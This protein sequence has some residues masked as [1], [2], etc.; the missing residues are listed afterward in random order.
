[1]LFQFDM[2]AFMRCS[3]ISAITASLH[4][5]PSFGHHTTACLHLQA[6]ATF[7]LQAAIQRSRRRAVHTHH[8]YR[9]EAPLAHGLS[10]INGDAFASLKIILRIL[11]TTFLHFDTLL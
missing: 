5:K 1:M 4:L 6:A 3:G 10:F 7:S 9:G 8:I 2:V 11:T